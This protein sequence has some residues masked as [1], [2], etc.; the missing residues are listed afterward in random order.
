M[1]NTIIKKRSTKV[2]MVILFVSAFVAAT[3]AYGSVGQGPIKADKGGVICIDEDTKLIIPAGALS[4]N[5]RIRVKMVQNDNKV[6]FDFE[7]EGIQFNKPVY[8]QKKLLSMWD[9]EW[10]FALYY[11]PDPDDL[12]QY[13]EVI[14]PV[15]DNSDIKWPLDHFSLYYYRRR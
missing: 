4:K 7:P 11:A 15:L 2:L 1:L 3:I 6:T 9:A 5:T 14:E 10:G 12:E 13:T 8:L